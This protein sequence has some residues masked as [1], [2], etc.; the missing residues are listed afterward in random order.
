[1]LFE[2]PVGEGTRLLDNHGAVHLHM[3]DDGA[4]PV[5]GLLAQ[6]APQR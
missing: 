6:F 3:P 1:M 4:D 5:G 2:N